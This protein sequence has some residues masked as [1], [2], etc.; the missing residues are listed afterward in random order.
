M[1]ISVEQVTVINDNQLPDSP[2][3]D[4]KKESIEAHIKNAVEQIRPEV[5]YTFDDGG[6]SGHK[7]HVAVYQSV[8][9]I[10]S[11]A[12]RNRPTGVR[13]ICFLQTTSLWRKYLGVLDLPFS[14]LSASHVVVAGPRDIMCGERAMLAHRS[15]LEWFR[16]LYLLFSRY[17]VINSFSVDIF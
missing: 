15:Q 11:S 4:W 2:T 9:N 12:N 1:G 13:A 5:V 10:F 16:F 17:M 6:V 3:E 14:F 7:N 8:K